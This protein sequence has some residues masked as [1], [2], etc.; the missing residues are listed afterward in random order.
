MRPDIPDEIDIDGKKIPVNK[1]HYRKWALAAGNRVIQFS[2]MKPMRI[3]IGDTLF[4]MFDLSEFVKINPDGNGTTIQLK[5]PGPKIRENLVGIAGMYYHP[6]NI[7]AENTQQVVESWNWLFDRNNLQKTKIEN[8]L[9]GLAIMNMISSGQN[10]VALFNIMSLAVDLKKLFELGV[11][12]DSKI[13]ELISKIKGNWRAFNRTR[14][15]SIALALVQFDK[16]TYA[17]SDLLAESRL[18]VLAK[19]LGYNVKLNKSPDLLIDGIKI[20]VKFDRRKQMSDR[21]FTNKVKKGLKQGGKMVAIFTGSFKIKKFGHSKLKWFAISPIKDS[22]K[23]SLQICKNKKQCVL[24]FT[25][26]NK[27]FVGRHAIIR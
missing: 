5:D 11:N 6:S 12:V 13:S 8:F 10:E 16:L 15:K 21:A 14:E 27:G 4:A 20:E 24:L 17:M 2:K 23:M 19:E 22:L 9:E 25:G 26:T 7:G 3:K 1:E 18:A